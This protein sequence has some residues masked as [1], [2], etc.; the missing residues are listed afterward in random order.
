MPQAV[1]LTTA[2]PRALPSSP[3]ATSNAIGAVL[4]RA[5]SARPRTLQPRR[6]RL[7]STRVER[8]VIA[9]PLAGPRRRSSDGCSAL[10][11][12]PSAFIPPVPS[13]H[14]QRAG[15]DVE[16]R[17][18][19][20]PG[21]RRRRASPPR[22]STWISRSCPALAAAPLRPVRTERVASSGPSRCV[23]GGIGH[24][25]SI[26]TRWAGRITR[27]PNEG[28]RHMAIELDHSFTTAKPIDE[29]FAAIIDLERAIPCVEGGRVIER[30][31]PDSVKAEIVVRMGAMSMTFTGTVEVVEKDPA[32]H[33]AVLRG[34]VAGGR[35]PG[36]R[37]RRRR[38]SRSTTAAA[39]IHTNA[40]IT[41]KAAS[42]GEGVVV[43]RARRADH[44]LHRQARADALRPVAPRRAMRRDPR[45]A[46]CPF[47]GGTAIQE[48]PGPPGLPRQRPRRLRLRRVRQRPRR[49]DARDADDQEGPGPLRRLPDGQRRGRGRG[50]DR[51]LTGWLRPGMGI[52]HTVVM[53]RHRRF[54]GGLLIAVA[55]IATAAPASAKQPKLQ[56]ASYPDMST[57]QCRTDAIPIH[58][59]QNLNDFNVT[60]T[61]PTRSR[62]AGPATR[63][64][65]PP[66]RPPRATSR[67][68][69]RAWSRSRATAASSR[70]AS[71]TST[72]TTSSGSRTGSGRPSP[73]ARRRRSRRCR[74]ATVSRSAPPRTG[75]STR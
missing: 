32:A 62:S 30:T 64:S 53:G 74:R 16:L 33:R 25:P 27:P 72:C 71:G 36:A 22:R 47:D 19:S 38:P 9:L 45:R 26:D 12:S 56:A 39:T 75:A 55:F 24:G 43:G 28:D 70:R 17:S 41:G 65:S 37:E 73:P 68:S 21:R 10:S 2:S 49:V 34:Q 11:S 52:R 18:R 6:R 61:C 42:M 7:G 48:D 3:S 59:G 66:A 69:S 5:A 8:N 35:R 50:G 46:R 44:R 67:A 58:P 51:R 1:C 4:R 14:A 20:R 13:M 57:Y 31:G 29:S 54:L 63:A 23:P 40:Q 60:K 15:V